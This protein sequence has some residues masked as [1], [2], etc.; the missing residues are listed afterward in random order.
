MSL[1]NKLVLCGQNI[2]R[3]QRR[4]F[5]QQHIRHSNFV[6]FRGQNVHR[7]QRRLFSQQ[8][9]VRHSNF[10]AFDV[11][12]PLNLSSL[13]TEEEQL[14]QE[15]ARNFSDSAL[16][17][18]IVQQYRDESWD[19]NIIPEMGSMGL[20]GSTIHGYGCAG[21]SPVSYGLTCLEV[22]RVDSAYRSTL[23]VQ[24]SLVMGPI[25]E[26]GSESLKQKYLPSLATGEK[27]GCFGLT[28]P[29]AGSDPA[30]M[31]T[32]CKKLSDADGMWEISGSKTWISHS[33]VADVFII[34]CRHHET[35]KI[36]GFVLDKEQH[37]QWISCP[38]IEGKLSLRASVTG[39]II[40]DG[41]RVHES[42]MLDVE[43]LKGPFSCLNNARYGIA[44]GAL[45]AAQDCLAKA[46]DYTM[47][48][49]MFSFPLA[50]YQLIQYKMADI[51]SEI[52]IG[53][54]SC[55]QVGRLKENG[56]LNPTQISI[57]KRNSCAKAL[58]AARDCRDILGGNGIIDEY[59]VFRHVCNLETVNTYEGTHDIHSLIIGRAITGIQAFDHNG[60]HSA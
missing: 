26:F 30:A 34:W 48:R 18:R 7:P 12:D 20:L 57:I 32:T 21:V 39:M 13:L 44:W 15:T 4:L 27:V 53:L 52:A 33:P 60:P 37:G 42:Q 6:A 3:S 46:V 10:V 41:V 36:K 8:Q 17:P 5:T 56:I 24:S 55:V 19:P 16:R 22:E 58:R 59:D 25:N 14:V 35:G 43:G 9:H 1:R 47:N 45:G 38:K 54:Q 31:R 2:L 29:D 49:T 23:S 50:S 51:L 11:N 40:M 28:E